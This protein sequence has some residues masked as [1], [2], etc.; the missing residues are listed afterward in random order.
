VQGSPTWCSRAP[1]RPQGPTRSPAGICVARG[2]AIHPN[3]LAFLL[4]LCFERCCPKQ[5]PASRWRSQYLVSLKISC[6]LS[7]RPRACSKNS[8][9]VI[10]V[11]TLPNISIVNNKIIKGKFGNIFISEMCLNVVALCINPRTKIRSHL[12]KDWW[13]LL[14]SS[15]KPII[16]KCILRSKFSCSTVFSPCR[17]SIKARVQQ[18]ILIC[19]YTFGCNCDIKMDWMGCVGHSL[20]FWATLRK[21]FVPPSVP[22]WLR[23]CFSNI[24]L[25]CCKRLPQCVVTSRICCNWIRIW[26]G[27]VE[28]W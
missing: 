13:S 16:S 25:N 17:D 3:F 21:R 28:R 1:G 4:F 6:W 23:A 19:F 14:Q 24:L 11:L 12:Q 9:S 22:S 18:Q 8:I 7:Y 26:P 10:G 27:G 20:K 2:G 15:W 5:D